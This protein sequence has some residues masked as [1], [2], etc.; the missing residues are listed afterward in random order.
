[1]IYLDHHATTPLDPRVLEAMMP[2][3]KECYGNPSS[4]NHKFGWDAEEAVEKAREQI[5][6]LI[7]CNPHQIIFTSGA[8]ESN[9]M[10]LR[11]NSIKSIITS[12]I[13]HSSIIETYNHLKNIH[14]AVLSVNDNGIIN[15]DQLKFLPR[16]DLI[17][18]MFVNNEIGTIQDIGK[19]GNE[20]LE[21]GTLLHSDMA[22][23][24]GKI[25]VDVK[26]LN[27][28]FA[29]FSAHKIYG[30][31]GVG[32]LFVKNF[33]SIQPLLHGGKQEHGYRPGTLN[34]PAV[35][36]F[37][38]ACEIIDYELEDIQNT[39]SDNAECLMDQLFQIPGIKYHNFSPQVPGCIHVALPCDN[40]SL[41][42]SMLANDV[43]FSTGSACMSIN[44][45]PSRVLEAIQLPEEEATRSVRICV[46]KFN[47]FD[48]LRNAANLIKQAVKKC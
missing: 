14:K 42:L 21:P 15:I 8:T 22:Q 45:E 2:Y 12:S 26:K 41:L 29:S 7:N 27:V 11:N 18:V 9:N 10:V 38:K 30:P 40:I 46:G 28:D 39:L 25:S 47:T 19:I 4:R 16:P 5:A 43:A 33:D 37:G 34:V 48:E 6:K 13:E 36:G 17:S 44:N 35:V 23:A 1:M 20:L 24:L 31:K 3:F 32:A